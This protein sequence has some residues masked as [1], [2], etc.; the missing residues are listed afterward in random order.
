M[1]CGVM[2]GLDRYLSQFHLEIQVFDFWNHSF[3]RPAWTTGTLIPCSFLCGI[4]A[5]VFIWHGGQKTKRVE[6][7][8]QRLQA[9]LNAETAEHPESGRN[10]QAT[11]MQEKITEVQEPQE[12]PQVTVDEQMTVPPLREKQEA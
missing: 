6:E 8:K 1:L 3:Q 4:G 9:A 10:N 11:R 2:W 7:V 5:G 12:D